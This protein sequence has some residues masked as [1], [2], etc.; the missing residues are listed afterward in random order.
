MKKLLCIALA[1]TMVLGLAITAHAE[2]LP[3]TPR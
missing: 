3:A 2:T 1:L